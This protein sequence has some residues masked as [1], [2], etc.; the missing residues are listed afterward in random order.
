MYNI[1]DNWWLYILKY[2]QS[3]AYQT[4]VYVFYD[5]RSSFCSFVTVYLS[6]FKDCQSTEI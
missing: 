6:N 2:G 1:I 4:N 3:I 5:Y